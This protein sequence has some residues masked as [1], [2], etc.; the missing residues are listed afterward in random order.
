M[1]KIAVIGN[2]MVHEKHLL[3]WYQFRLCSN[4]GKCFTKVISYD[5]AFYNARKLTD[6]VVRKRYVITEWNLSL[7]L[8]YRK[9]N[10]LKATLDQKLKFYHYRSI[11]KRLFEK[12]LF[13][14]FPNRFS[15]KTDH[16][17]RLKQ[18]FS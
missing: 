3:N 1:K 4:T 9:N 13:F 6:F 8:S 12:I 2:I 11:P 7:L 10:R 14:N 17:S 18:N 16:I 15:R 5:D